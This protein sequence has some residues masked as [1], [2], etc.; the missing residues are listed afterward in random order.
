M[1]KGTS[2]NLYIVN[3][4]IYILFV[5]YLVLLFYLVFFRY[6]VI[7]NLSTVFNVKN[8]KY[9]FRYSINIVPFK[10]ITEYLLNPHNLSFRIRCTNILG[11]I[12]AFIPF[13]FF[14]TVIFKKLRGTKQIITVSCM[15][16]LCI[17][18]IQLI[19]LVG[20]FD[21]DDIILN[22]TGGF[23]GYLLFILFKQS[24]KLTKK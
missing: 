9:Y 3:I 21:V 6:R 5:V 7:G 1:D 4:L 11:N 16:S 22:T 13:G 10:T 20:S 19:F 24:Y 23:L 8:Y 14:S 18:V 15:F 12:L 17:E 2:K